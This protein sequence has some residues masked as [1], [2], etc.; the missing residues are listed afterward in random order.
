MGYVQHHNSTDVNHL[1]AYARV[2]TEAMEAIQMDR[3][4]PVQQLVLGA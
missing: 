4:S 1:Q 3:Q 2:S